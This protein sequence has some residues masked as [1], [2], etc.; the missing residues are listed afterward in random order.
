MKCQ[1][2]DWKHIF[3]YWWSWWQIIEVIDGPKP[4]LEFCQFP[5]QKFQVYII[6]NC[7]NNHIGHTIFYGKSL[8]NVIQANCCAAESSLPVWGWNPMRKLFS[9]LAMKTESCHD[10]NFIVTGDTDQRLSLWQWRQSW[11]DN[12]VFSLA[13]ECNDAC[14]QVIWYF[15]VFFLMCRNNQLTNSILYGTIKVYLIKK[16]KKKKQFWKIFVSYHADMPGKTNGQTGS[17]IGTDYIPSGP[18]GW[19]FDNKNNRNKPEVE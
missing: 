15:Y 19:E 16:K 2:F 13:N 12:S 18:I 10:T 3:L 6:K 4:W 9:A 11:S 17:P 14:Q 1:T 7:I 8:W 5:Q